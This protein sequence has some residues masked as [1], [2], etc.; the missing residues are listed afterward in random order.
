ML[1][2]EFARAKSSAVRSA[3]G[4]ISRLPLPPAR[5][6][7]P[8]PRSLPYPCATPPPTPHLPYLSARQKCERRPRRGSRCPWGCP[9]FRARLVLL[10]TTAPPAVF[11]LLLQP[12]MLIPP[13]RS[14]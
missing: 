5:R 2:A 3:S 14:A 1:S 9:S 8:H 13:R 11:L 7:R 12:S 6:R 4:E 10:P